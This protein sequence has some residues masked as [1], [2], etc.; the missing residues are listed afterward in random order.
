MIFL[1]FVRIIIIYLMSCAI[2]WPLKSGSQCAW[3]VQV[4][5]HSKHLIN[6]IYNF[7]KWYT[8]VLKDVK[9]EKNIKVSTKK[10]NIFDKKLV[11]KLQ[12]YRCRSNVPDEKLRIWTSLNWNPYTFLKIFFF[13]KPHVNFF[14]LIFFYR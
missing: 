3:W 8:S 14:F 1:E 11:E 10:Q 13:L 9:E 4:K 2:S 5:K 6:L 12:W 7:I